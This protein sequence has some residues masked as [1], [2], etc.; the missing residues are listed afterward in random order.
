MNHTTQLNE[1]LKQLAGFSSSTPRRVEITDPNGL[2]LGVAVV[3]VD[4][5]SC[6]FESLTLHVPALVGNESGAIQAWADALSERVTYLLENIGPIEIDRQ[7]S[8]VLI[9]STP[10]DRTSTGTQFYEVL[11]S[12][13]TNGTFLLRRY[14]AES[15]QPG[16]ESVDIH[17]THETLHKLVGDLVETIPQLADE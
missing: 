13:Q 14:R 6:A 5:L 10:P 15:G 17:L 8:Q 11:L 1:E 7:S 12:A 3:A 4:A 2:I 9:R 16:R